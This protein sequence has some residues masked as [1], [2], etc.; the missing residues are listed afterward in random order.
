MNM[1]LFVLI[2]LCILKYFKG[3]ILHIEK[4]DKYNAHE[5]FGSFCLCNLDDHQKSIKKSG[6]L[7]PHH[8][9][10]FPNLEHEPWY[11]GA[12]SRIDAENYLKLDSNKTGS[13]LIR[14]SMNHQIENDKFHLYTLSVRDSNNEIRHYKIYLSKDERNHTFY[15]ISPKVKL[16]KNIKELINHF[17]EKVD[18]LCNLLTKPCQSIRI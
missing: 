14:Y 17:E 2:F 1:W 5:W 13:F 11:F 18:G 12:L 7:S 15:S 8:V 4:S 16:F 9:A 10:Y 6:T 3:D